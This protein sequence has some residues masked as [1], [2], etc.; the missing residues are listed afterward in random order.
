MPPGKRGQ[1]RMSVSFHLAMGWGMEWFEFEAAT[2]LPCET[3]ATAAALADAF[4]QADPAAFDIPRST[5]EA[6]EASTPRSVFHTSNPLHDNVLV[7][8]GDRF[9]RGDPS[10]LFTLV[11]DSAN[12]IDA[13]V[14]FFPDC[15]Y[16]KLWQR[17]GDDLDLA[18]LH[19][20]EKGG[21]RDV[22]TS[23][24][25][26]VKYV[27]FG[28]GPFRNDLM[29]EDGQPT[30]WI[31]FPQLVGRDDIVPRVPLAMRWYLNRLGV[32]DHAG[33]NRLR[34]VIARWFD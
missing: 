30:D 19:R 24:E 1:K 31:P 32:L 6:A 21:K 33:V 27:S 9:T 8:A 15:Y 18:F 13:H 14:I 20:W 12:D 28:H 26:N 17:T 4:A 29:T 23:S 11:S 2:T 10:G 22:E 25:M 7:R 16:A 5:I 34:P 3:H